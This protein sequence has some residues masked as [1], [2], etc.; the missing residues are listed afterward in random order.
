[1][2]FPSAKQKNTSYDLSL[3]IEGTICHDQTKVANYLSEHFTN[4]AYDTG[5]PERSTIDTH[6]GVQALERNQLVKT[7]FTYTV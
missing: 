2:P 4:I 7:V 6:V 1:M 3:N 5:N